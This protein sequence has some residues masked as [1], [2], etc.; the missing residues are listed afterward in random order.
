[1]IIKIFNKNIL[2]I[3]IMKLME[4]KLSG[5]IIKKRIDKILSQ[6]YAF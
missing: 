4:P 3:E 5:K 2:S 6:L 1:M